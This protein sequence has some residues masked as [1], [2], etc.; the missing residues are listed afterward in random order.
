M[1]TSSHSEKHTL[2][3]HPSRPRPGPDTIAYS[4]SPISHSL[5]PYSPSESSRSVSLSLPKKFLSFAMVAIPT[6]LLAS[7]AIPHLGSL[8]S[9]DPAPNPFPLPIPSS[10]S[11]S[12]SSAFG[13]VLGP[14]ISTNFADPAI[15]H[16]D[17]TSYAFATNNR[18]VGPDLIHVQIA[19]SIDNHTWTLL[20][21]H[22]ALPQVGAWETGVR[23]WAPDV[24]RLVSY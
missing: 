20:E 24:V 6:Y 13:S 11:A 17:G 18:G 14:L 22:D 8:I 23:V 15:I 1:T 3:A 4:L 19:T 10:D 7:S 16:V 12:S 2:L 21:H 5:T 9:R